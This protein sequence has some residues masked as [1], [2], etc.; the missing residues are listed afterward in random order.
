MHRFHLVAE[1]TRCDQHG[2]KWRSE[3]L[4][5]VGAWIYHELPPFEVL[6]ELHNHGVLEIGVARSIQM[7]ANKRTR[8]HPMH[9]ASANDKI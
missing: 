3:Y 1:L 4:L 5:F 9:L 7:D 6:R 8:R 2:S